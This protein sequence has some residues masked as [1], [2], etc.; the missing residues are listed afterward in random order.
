[1]GAARPNPIQWL[2][3]AVGGRLPARLN[4]WVLHD[5]TCPSWVWRHTARSTVVISPFT[6][7]CLLVPG[8]LWVRL[9]MM[10]LAVLVGYYFSFSYMVESCEHRAAKHGH[11]PGTAH[12]I[13]QAARE[14]AHAEANARARA[15]YDA[16]YRQDTPAHIAPDAETR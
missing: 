8:P 12:G 16:R 9:G 4:E 7:A 1:M 5:V 14:E 13:R 10:G 11:A 15:R 2:W 3:Y 6:L